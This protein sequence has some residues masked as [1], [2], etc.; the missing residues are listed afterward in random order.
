M[1]EKI[2]WIYAHWQGMENPQLMGTLATQQARGK[3]IFSFS[4]DTQWLSS[5]AALY[6]IDPDL[7]L[8]EGRQY[9]HPT[10]INFGLFLDSAPDRWGR[11]LMQRRHAIL[12]K[13]QNKPQVLLAESDYLLG[14]HDVAR[15]G[16]LRFK[17]DKDG[18]FIAEDSPYATPPWARLRELEYGVSKIEEDVPSAEQEKWLAQLVAPGSSL[19]GARPKATV[20]DENGNLWIAKFP[21]KNDPHDSGA[22]EMVFHELAHDAGIEVPSARIQQ[23]SSHG[24]TFLVQRF[25]RSKT[26]KRIHFASA[27]ALLGKQDGQ[28]D[29]S[30]LDLAEFII[31]ASSQPEEDLHQLWRRIVFNI[32]VSN[33]DDHLRNHGFLLTQN[34][35]KLAPSYDVNPILSSFGL[36]LAIDEIDHSLSFT[37]ALKVAPFFYLTNKKATIILEEVKESVS[38]WETKAKEYGLSSSD[39]LYM[40][41]AFNV[42]RT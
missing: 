21:S 39:C 40:E 26:G 13:S 33:S 18:P 27:M 8:F 34:G 5:Q 17:I 11:T 29:V 35:W 30:Y 15:M 42:Y 10:K 31:Q 16:A 20:V 14:V 32:A 38:G 23:F 6:L 24:S 9:P 25:D 28:S 7:Q 1:K 4:Y 3:E 36:S 2:I 19:G 12:S 37:L 41:S 22:W